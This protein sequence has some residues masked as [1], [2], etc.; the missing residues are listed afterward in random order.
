MGGDS[1]RYVDVGPPPRDPEGPFA[2]VY[3]DLIDPWALYRSVRS[4]IGRTLVVLGYA[5]ITIGILPI[6]Y[7][8][9]KKLR[10]KRYRKLFVD[11]HAVLGRILAVTPDEGSVTSNV[12]FAYEVEGVITGTLVVVGFAASL[13]LQAL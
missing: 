10:V 9:D 5:V 7:A 11:G 13:G 4:P 3:T 12:K 6:W 2:D 8:A 1:P